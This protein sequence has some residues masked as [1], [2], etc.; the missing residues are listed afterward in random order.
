MLSKQRPSYS[1]WQH[2]AGS[3][4]NVALRVQLQALPSNL[5]GHQY[6]PGC[7]QMHCPV[8]GRPAPVSYLHGAPATLL[9]R[10]F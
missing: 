6:R 8:S 7:H 5:I 10:V 2:V 3:I 4:Q 1:R 9:L